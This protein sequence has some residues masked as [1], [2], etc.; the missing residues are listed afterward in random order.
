M[1]I[2]FPMKNLAIAAD[3]ELDSKSIK[4][5]TIG[6]SVILSCRLKNISDSSRMILGYAWTKNK[7]DVTVDSRF[8][9]L[10]WGGLLVRRVKVDD[11]GTYK[12]MAKTLSDKDVPKVYR[13]MEVKMDILYPPTIIVIK[14]TVIASEGSNV[15][16][17]CKSRGNPSVIT[18]KWLWKGKHLSESSAAV[19]FQNG[20][21]YLKNV[22]SDHEGVYRCTPFNKV[23]LGN[24]AE[25][26]LKVE[27]QLSF[28]QVP[29]RKLTAKLGES[30]TMICKA[31]TSP[32]T[33]RK[34][35][36]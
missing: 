13:G 26:I 14:P 12:C 33:W 32:I 2:S 29:P 7:V 3:K 9:V 8:T 20:T 1:L 30:L 27:A 34:V 22:N 21:L 24:S 15:Q 18:T 16:L 11:A 17:P 28:T 5:V 10:M 23:G 36:D 4:H 25:T 6:H 35:N 31:K 19:I